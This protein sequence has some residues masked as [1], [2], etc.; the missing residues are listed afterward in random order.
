MLNPPLAEDLPDWVDAPSQYFD[1]IKYER[2]KFSP[3]FFFD[4]EGLLFRLN[5]L[6][7]R[8]PG[9]I[10]FPFARHSYSDDVACW[11]RGNQGKVVI[12]H[13]YASPGWEQRKIFSSFED[14][15]NFVLSEL[16]ED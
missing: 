10:L 6:K 2:D 14:W 16:E 4:R 3:W 15:F 1:L 8:Y 5:G 13:D 9:R 12:I 7:N 11:E